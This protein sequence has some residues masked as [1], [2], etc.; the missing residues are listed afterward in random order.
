MAKKPIS[1]PVSKPVDRPT[2]FNANEG[3]SKYGS[4][5][6]KKVDTTTIQTRNRLNDTSNKQ[7][8]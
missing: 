3:G 7:S 2:K 8:E 4:A 6:D 1:K 5:K